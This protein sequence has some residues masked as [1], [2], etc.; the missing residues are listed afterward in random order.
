MLAVD[1]FIASIKEDIEKRRKI[2]DDDLKSH[3]P[4][5]DRIVSDRLAKV[6]GMQEYLQQ[7]KL[8]KAMYENQHVVD[9][10]SHAT[11]TRRD[12]HKRYLP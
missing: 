4:I 11:V 10:R 6:K 5:E 3:V 9:E 7:A 12:L 1:D 2:R 8:K